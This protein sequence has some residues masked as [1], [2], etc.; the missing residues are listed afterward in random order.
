MMDDNDEIKMI[1][2]LEDCGC[3]EKLIEQFLLYRKENEI[4]KQMSLLHRHR[5]D[6]LD[7]LHDDQRKIDCLEYII[8]RIEKGEKI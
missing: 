4:K 8:Y 5:Y 1:S 2:C 6:L 3:P 7:I